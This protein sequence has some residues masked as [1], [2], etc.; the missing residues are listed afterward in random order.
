MGASI[1]CAGGAEGVAMVGE[2]DGEVVVM[3]DVEDVAVND[4]VQQQRLTHDERIL[5]LWDQRRLNTCIFL[6]SG[7]S[8]SSF[9]IPF[10]FLRLERVYPTCCAQQ[11]HHRSYVILNIPSEACCQA[12]DQRYSEW[13]DSSEV[14]SSWHVSSLDP[15]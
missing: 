15:L 9:L 6:L 11:R 14:H 7:D 2:N 13:F 5:L 8:S 4:R 12:A 3:N 10:L 1:V